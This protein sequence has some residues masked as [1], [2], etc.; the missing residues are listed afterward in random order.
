ML[1]Q[2]TCP[3]CGVTG[4][5]RDDGQGH[6][7]LCP[8]CGMRF[9]LPARPGADPGLPPAVI[10]AGGD[11]RP[12]AGEGADADPFGDPARSGYYESPAVDADAA[13]PHE[14][15]GRRRT[16]VAVKGTR[17]WGEWLA[18]VSRASGLPAAVMVEVALAEW[19]ARQGYP[20]P[21][22]R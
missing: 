7:V 4:R 12:G 9:D 19:A 11:P 2:V 6:R 17:E 14:A 1:I 10:A 21:P 18:S 3:H 20:A 8:R 22:E 15:S 13:S 16:I 5:L